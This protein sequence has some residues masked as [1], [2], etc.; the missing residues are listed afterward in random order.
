MPEPRLTLDAV[1]AIALGRGAFEPTPVEWRALEEAHRFL[2]EAS[3]RRQRIYGVTTGYG[4]LAS[5]QVDPRQSAQL[6]QH[7]VAHLCT[8]VGE[9]LSAAQTRAM[10]LAR[11]LSLVRGYSGVD[12]ALVRRLLD[13]LDADVLPEVPA[14]GSVGASGDL[15]PLA[16]LARALSGAGRVRLRG[17]AWMSSAAAHQALGW[18]PLR[19]QGKDAIALVNGTSATAGM[20]VLNA[21]RARRAL[22]ISTLCVLLYAELLRG[23]REAF[24]P[25][26][27]EL[28]RHPGQQRLHRWLWSLSADSGAL[29]PWQAEGVRLPA[30]DADIAQRQPLPQDAYSLRCAPQALGAVLDVIEQHAEMVRI[31]LDAV[32]DNPLLFV[33]EG[34]VLHGGNFFGQHLAFASDHLNNALIQM[35][36]Y[37]ERRIARVTDPSLNA[38]LPAFGQP[39]ATGLHSGFMGAQVS[40]T[41][42]VA[43]LRAEAMPASIQ[44]IPTNANNQDIVPIATLAARRAGTSLEHLYRILAIEAMV[45]AQAADWRG[46]ASLSPASRA[47]CAWV[48]ERIAPLEQDRPLAEEIDALAE[49]LADP[50]AVS[51]L[52]AWLTD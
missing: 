32:T 47:C 16:H 11:L 29:L 21:T 43:E 36:L 33:A 49:A 46:W 27:G 50:E 40:A 7:L 20:A 51:A 52:L 30:M 26:F 35:A 3:A 23:H 10:M 6:Q 22:G 45:L 31:E 44:S 37:S 1:E 12:P 9:P 15:T 48:R 24:H 4:P 34:Q 5:T 13:W 42:L 17:G 14:R 18:E 2:C 19:L 28:R 39:H 25:G 8:G 41:A 38:G